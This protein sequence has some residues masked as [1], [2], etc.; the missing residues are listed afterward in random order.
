MLEKIS[1]HPAMKVF[2][3]RPNVVQAIRLEKGM[4]LPNVHWSAFVDGAFV[5]YAPEKDQNLQ[6][7]AFPGDYLLF[8]QALGWTGVMKKDEFEH[9]YEALERS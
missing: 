7:F 5:L 1:R 8:D 6:A 3:C 4:E 9:K 2:K